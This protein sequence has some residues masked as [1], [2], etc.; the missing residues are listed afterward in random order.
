M[1][2]FKSYTLHGI[3]GRPD[4][5]CEHHRQ[6]CEL[7]YI[8]GLMAESPYHSPR[9]VSDAARTLKL[10]QQL[11]QVRVYYS[12]YGRCM[13]YVVWAMLAQD[14]YAQFKA[15]RVRPLEQFE[16]NEGYMPWIV[17]FLV[18]PGSL[19][20]VARDLRTKLFVGCREISYIR[21]RRGQT[22]RRTHR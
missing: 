11:G 7:G 14:T 17:D 8:L 9:R 19:V 10:A 12:D 18:R 5:E 3:G 1:N 2:N 15:G 21:T 16:W 13:G 20:Y 4:I 22:I 6:T